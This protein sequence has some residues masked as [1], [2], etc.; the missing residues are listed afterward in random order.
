M[1]QLNLTANDDFQKSILTYL[2]ANASEMLAAKIN[3]ESHISVDGKELI[4]KKDLNSFVGYAND[5]ALKFIA[6]NERK[7]VKIL[8]I[9]DPMV[10]SWAIHYFEEESIQGTLYNLD[11]T[12][13]KK[14]IPKATTS[15]FMPKTVVSKR[16]PQEKEKQISIFDFDNLS[17]NPTSVEGTKT[18]YESGN[19]ATNQAIDVI[20]E[21][22]EEI[23]DNADTEELKLAQQQIQQ[24]VDEYANV[25]SFYKKYCKVKSEYLD[26]LVLYRLGDFYEM[27][28]KDAE[29]SGDILDLTITGRDVGLKE[30]VPLTGI[31]YH[32]VDKYVQKLSAKH[33]VLVYDNDQE[34]YLIENG[35]KIDIISGEVKPAF[36]SVQPQKQ[37]TPPTE[38]NPHIRY[39]QSLVK[40]L[41]A[42]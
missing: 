1:V 19:A 37:A 31:P 26:C 29:I 2:Q 15:T 25:K 7:G 3:K 38:S 8:H 33:K 9:E 42:D 14:E 30:R 12:L 6:E 39:L 11:G 27:F 34:Q 13:Y 32:A 23:Q 20:A 5:E 10:Y 41:R 16:Q 35:K 22:D 4:S 24:V 18:V 21:Q 17:S 36:E 28:D 40:D